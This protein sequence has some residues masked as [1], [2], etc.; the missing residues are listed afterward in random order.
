MIVEDG[1]PDW[2]VAVMWLTLYVINEQRHV[3]LNKF[4][5]WI[6]LIVPFILGCNIWVATDI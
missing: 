3:F 6:I 5:K 4:K 1:D 2:A